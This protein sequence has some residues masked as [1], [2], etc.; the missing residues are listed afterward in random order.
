MSSTARPVPHIHRLLIRRQHPV[1][2]RLIVALLA[3][4]ALSACVSQGPD[5]P[6]DSDDTPPA[7][8]GAGAEPVLM[9]AEGEVSEPGLSV[10]DA[11]GHQ[12]TDD[13][14]TVTGALFV[15]ADGTVRLCD[16]IA[17]SFPPQCG[18]DR[19]EVRGLDLRNVADL[20][21]ESG[22]Q[23]SESVTLFGSVE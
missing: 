1:S 13:L 20:Q 11:L 12:A 10:A 9:I 7:S 15:D 23:W 21:E 6:A 3:A 8:V 22:V 17:E 18:G 19:I 2:N 4:F 16:A 5:T 14:V